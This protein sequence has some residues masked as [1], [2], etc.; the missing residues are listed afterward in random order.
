MA[1]AFRRQAEAVKASKIP[2][3]VNWV[4]PFHSEGADLR[5]DAE[6]ELKALPDLVESSRAAGQLYRS[7][8]A[9][10]GRE[11]KAIG[12]LRHRGDR[13]QCVSSGSLPDAGKLVIVRMGEGGEGARTVVFD[14]VGGVQHSEAAINVSPGPALLEGRPVFAVVPPAQ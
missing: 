12:W 11:Y 8:A 13:W 2:E 9:P 3:N 4:D 5:G 1:A 14:A 7:L 10:L 6:M